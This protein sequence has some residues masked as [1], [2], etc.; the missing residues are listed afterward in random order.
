MSHII[1][2]TE[3]QYDAALSQHQLVVAVTWDEQHDYRTWYDTE[4]LTL[5]MELL[6]YD[7]IIG[8]NLPFD[9]SVLINHYRLAGASA[10]DT[11]AFKAQLRSRAFDILAILYRST[12]RKASLAAVAEDVLA[13]TK[14][15]DMYQVR[16]AIEHGDLELVTQHCQRDVELTK[17]L[18]DQLATH[19]NFFFMGMEVKTDTEA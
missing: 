6:E 11:K 7:R 19:G 9:F 12:G 3:T 5:I 18:Y 10:K 4:D 8:Y 14:E 16:V 2:D 1:L 15:T 17:M 13:E